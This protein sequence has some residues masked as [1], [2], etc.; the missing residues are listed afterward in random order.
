M[1]RY[2]LKTSFAEEKEVSQ[3][4]FVLAE[5][6]AGFHPKYGCGPVATGGFSNGIVSGR[7]EYVTDKEET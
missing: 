4:E 1:Y 6:S 5:Q 2:F 7:V 3:D